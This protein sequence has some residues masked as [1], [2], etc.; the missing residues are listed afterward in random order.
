MP[1]ANIIVHKGSFILFK[2]DVEKEPHACNANDTIGVNRIDSHTLKNT[3]KG[4]KPKT[5]PRHLHSQ[6]SIVS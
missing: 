6:H 5:G 1:V 4:H 3:N 2:I